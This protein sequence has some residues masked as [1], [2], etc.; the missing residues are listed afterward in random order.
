MWSAERSEEGKSG[1]R[2][3]GG[4][5]CGV[6]SAAWS[7]IGNGDEEENVGGEREGRGRYVKTH[8]PGKDG[9]ERRWASYPPPWDHYLPTPMFQSTADD[10][11]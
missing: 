1:C 8:E 11:I 2:G 9:L 5:A 10:G 3:A 7:S 4:I 6:L